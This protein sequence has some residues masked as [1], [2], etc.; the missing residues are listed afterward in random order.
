MMM[1]NPPIVVEHNNDYVVNG[2]NLKFS[3][4][5]SSN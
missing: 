4:P 5:I 1:S 2:N 3:P